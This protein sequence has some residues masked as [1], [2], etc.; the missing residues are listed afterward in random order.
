MTTEVRIAELKARLSEYLRA[1]Q[2]GQEILVK[3]RDTP[4]ARLVPCTSPEPLVSRKPTR[5]LT[6]LDKLRGVK[7]KGLKPAEVEKARLETKRD[8]Y[9]KW[10]DGKSTSTRR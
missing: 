3:D 5:P 4:I 9:D 10:M 1:S 6:D 7:V 2:R 8:W